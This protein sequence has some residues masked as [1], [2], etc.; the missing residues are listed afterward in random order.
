[1][2]QIMFRTVNNSEQAQL[3]QDDLGALEEWYNLWQLKINAGK[4][5]VMHLGSR[6]KRIEYHM[7][8]GGVQVNVQTT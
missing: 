5:K 7:H 4:C 6:N 1:M 2:T 8:K 3:L